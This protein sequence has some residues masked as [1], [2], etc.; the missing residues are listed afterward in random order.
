MVDGSLV[1][2][3]GLAAFS[4]RSAGATDKIGQTAQTSSAGD[5]PSIEWTQRLI[6]QLSADGRELHCATR[7]PQI[8]GRPSLFTSSDR[9]IGPVWLLRR[10]IPHTPALTTFEMGVQQGSIAA[11]AGDAI[12]SDPRK[13]IDDNEGAV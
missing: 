2:C 3:A 4:D 10:G 7:P 9:S 8:N 11:L 6:C 1:G 13:S 5:V 12:S